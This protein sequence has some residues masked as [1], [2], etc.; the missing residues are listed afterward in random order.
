MLL[1][2][3]ILAIRSF[4]IQKTRDASQNTCKKSNITYFDYGWLKKRVSKNFFR[5]DK[6]EI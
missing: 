2:V 6:E 3:N 1:I 4:K 5:I